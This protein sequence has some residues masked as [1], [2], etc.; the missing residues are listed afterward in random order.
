MFTKFQQECLPRLL[1]CM[2]SLVSKVSFMLMKKLFPRTSALRAWLEPA[3]ELG[4]RGG[5]FRSHVLVRQLYPPPQKKKSAVA[6][7]CKLCYLMC[8]P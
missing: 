3:G 7:G 1:P 2:R 8:G 4:S 6:A 5:W